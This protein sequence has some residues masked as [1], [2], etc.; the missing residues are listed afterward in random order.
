MK[1]RLSIL[2]LF[3]GLAIMLIGVFGITVF[4]LESEGVYTITYHLDGG[5]NA[6]KNPDVYT[7]EDIIEL[8]DATKD[9]YTFDGWYLDASKTNKI[10]EISGRTGNINLYAKFSPKSYTATFNDEIK[11]TVCVPGFEDKIYY[12]PYGTSVDPYSYSFM[13]AYLPSDLNNSTTTRYNKDPRFSGWYVKYSGGTKTKI[14]G[15]LNIN[16]DTTI[17]CDFNKEIQDSYYLDHNE[18][19]YGTENFQKNI[20]FIG[21]LL[22]PTMSNGK[23]SIILNVSATNYHSAVYIRNRTTRDVYCD[24]DSYNNYIY[25]E[26]ITINANPGDVIEICVSKPDEGYITICAPGR[27][28]AP[29]V[30]KKNSKAT[31]YY[32]NM[33]DVP[34]PSSREGYVFVGWEDKN[35]NIFDGSKWTYLESMTFVPKFQPRKYSIKYELDGGVNNISNPSDYTIEDT[36]TLQAPSKTGYTF[37]GWFSDKALTIPVEKISDSTGDLTLYA[38]FSVN[39]YD[40]YLDGAGGSFSPKVVFV[41]EGQIIRTEYLGESDSIEAYRPGQ[42]EGYIFGGWYKDETLKS[43]FKFTG[44]ISDDITLYAKWIECDSD[45]IY[46]EIIEI[47]NATIN[48]KTEKYYAFVPLNDGTV[49]VTSDSD[50]L[51]LYGILYNSTKGILTQADDISDSDLDFSFSYNVKANQLYYICV[52]GNTASTKGDA[53]I[54]ITFSGNTVIS[55]TTYANREIEVAYGNNFSL[56]DLPVKEGYFFLGW[57]DETDTQVTNGKWEFISNKILTAKWRE[58][59]PHTI[60]FK[61]ENGQVLAVQDYLY[62]DVITPPK[63]PIKEADQTYTYDAQWNNDYSGIC[64]GDVIYTVEYTPVYI[65]YSVVFKDANGTVLSSQ[66]YHYGD[67]VTAPQT[68][69]KAADNTYTYTFA[70]WDKSTVPCAGNATY[71]ATYKATYI[72][73]TVEF[74]DYDGNTISSK[75]YHYGDVITVPANPE[76]EADNTYTYVFAGWDK[77]VI[78][79][80]GSNVCFALLISNPCLI[81]TGFNIK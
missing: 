47:F 34:Q 18:L 80:A 79:C 45:I 2:G 3:F 71:T 41:S 58:K 62:G 53:V 49:K 11:L 67:A 17:V 4:A 38:K 61:D 1:K 37:D 73:Y 65:D 7:A 40:L 77:S 51:D 74:K 22:V 35:G 64:V 44:T 29:L 54:N 32:D 43:A 19:S 12:V 66:A 26:T 59:T 9:G 33:V 36:V 56:P 76:R 10:T 31:V 20:G 70:G 24:K 48:G 30:S 68:P 27:V 13:R 72:D 55:G 46:P 6:V 75:I 60:T 63:F 39:T 78:S 50:N 14:S 42:R 23:F 57:Y 16:T 25:N 69:T 8:K 15:S 81:A 21:N 5:T 52:K 28:T